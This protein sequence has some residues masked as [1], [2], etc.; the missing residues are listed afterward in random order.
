VDPTEF[1][2]P[3]AGIAL[4]VVLVWISSGGRQ[5]PVS[6]AAANEALLAENLE[7]ANIAIGRRGL[8]GLAWLAGRERIAL[9]RRMGNHIG[10]TVLEPGDIRQLDLTG[11]PPVLTIRFNAIGQAPA[12]LDFNDNDELEKWRKALMLYGKLGASNQA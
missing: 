8:T 12:K 5:L 6:K 1:I 9:L 11:D 10:V 2:L 3:L 4:I 7:A